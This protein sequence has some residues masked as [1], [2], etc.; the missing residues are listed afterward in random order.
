MLYNCFVFAELSKRGAGKAALTMQ[1]ALALLSVPV[2][3][4]DSQVFCLWMQC[5][6]EGDAVW[7]YRDQWT[8]IGWVRLDILICRCLARWSLSV[9]PAP[10]H[11]HALYDRPVSRSTG[12]PL[13]AVDGA[14]G[15]EAYSAKTACP[16][17]EVHP[18]GNNAEREAR[19]QADVA[20]A[21]N[22]PGYLWGPRDSEQWK[23]IRETNYRMA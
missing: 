4:D 1:P 2:L 17:N 12:S 15:T 14:I 18:A 16:L 23:I 13:I 11:N 5:G 7:I 9:R 8:W 10:C 6:S 20:A 21:C 22:H 3:D 19:P